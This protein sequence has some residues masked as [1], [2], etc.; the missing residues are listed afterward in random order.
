MR[1]I[2]EI[3]VH[4]TATSQDVL[5]EQI[6]RYHVSTKKWVDCGYHFL[7]DSLGEVHPMRPLCKVG[8]HCLG[9][10]VHSIG[11]AYIGGKV[12]DNRTNL[13]KEALISLMQKL[14]N[15]FPSIEKISGHYVYAP[16]SCPNFNVQEEYQNL[17]PN[18]ICK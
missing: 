1:T 8:A 5:P 11:I 12:T 18:I 13:Q 3:I 10:N 14:I 2:N 7:V 6:K 15:Q 9:K 4:C 16:K 17:F